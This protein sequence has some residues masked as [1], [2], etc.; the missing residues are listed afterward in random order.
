MWSNPPQKSPQAVKITTY[1]FLSGVLVNPN[2][3]SSEHGR[4]AVR[5]LCNTIEETFSTLTQMTDRTNSDDLRPTPLPSNMRSLEFT[6]AVLKHSFK[7]SKIADLVR[8]LRDMRS[9]VQTC[10]TKLETTFQ[11]VHTLY[12]IMNNGL[13]RVASRGSIFSTSTNLTA[14]VKLAG[15][16]KGLG[17]KSRPS[18]HQRSTS[19]RNPVS[20]QTPSHSV[21]SIGFVTFLNMNTWL[22]ESLT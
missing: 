12:D 20:S 17:G 4:S 13:A 1:T 16:L 3:H 19:V 8:C 10:L 21:F 11:H 14:R 9:D 15:W 6:R 2:M 18:R 22:L 5:E 7:P